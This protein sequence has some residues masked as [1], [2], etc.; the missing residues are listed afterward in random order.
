M[1]KEGRGGEGKEDKG[2]T[3]VRSGLMADVMI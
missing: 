3:R 2:L 1:E